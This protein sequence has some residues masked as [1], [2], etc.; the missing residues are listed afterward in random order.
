MVQIPYR[1]T[2][3][4]HGHWYGHWYVAAGAVQCPEV[5]AGAARDL[6]VVE[7][8]GS[9]LM[10]AAADETLLAVVVEADGTLRFPY[11]CYS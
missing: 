2:T 3:R 6:R 1:W 8:G 7:V 9:G 10:E 5:V 4:W 11:Y